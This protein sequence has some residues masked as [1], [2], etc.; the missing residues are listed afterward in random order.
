M[1]EKQK[2]KSPPKKNS[3]RASSPPPRSSRERQSSKEQLSR[4][5]TRRAEVLK[6][7]KRR[8]RNKFIAYIMIVIV[9]LIVAITLSLTV[10]F[11]TKAITVTGDEIYNYEQITTASTINIGDNLFLT[12]KKAVASAIETALP[13]VEKVE[14]KCHLSGTMEIK[15][16]AAKVALAIFNGETYTLLNSNCKVLENN[17]M[18]I[19]DDVI[20]LNTGE[21]ISANLGEQIVFSNEADK[22]IIAKFMAALSEY[23]FTGVTA[24]DISKPLNV[25]MTY[26]GTAILELG[27]VESVPQKMPF[28]KK[29]MENLFKE[30]PSFEGTVNFTIDKKAY[31]RDKRE[32]K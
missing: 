16:T 30:R 12:K 28:I 31:V 4:D 21:I 19:N 14:L 15:I 10:F 20:L 1:T 2:S 8:K 26:K 7:R 13:Y 27:V 11:G 22:D 32:E 23:E 6:R 24:I 5:E 29:T 25:S 3:Q 18:V 9:L 17:S